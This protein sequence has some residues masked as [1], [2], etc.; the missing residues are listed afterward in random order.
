MP[1]GEGFRLKK[2]GEPSEQR[3]KT[4]AQIESVRAEIYKLG[5]VAEKVDMRLSDMS[6]DELLVELE[7]FERQLETR[8]K[9]LEKKI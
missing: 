4:I 2:A 3:L 9:F 6:E 5:V 8:K 1:E 7:A